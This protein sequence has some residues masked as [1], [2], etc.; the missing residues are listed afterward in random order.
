MYCKKCGATVPE[1]GSFCQKCG[2]AVD[3]STAE[4]PPPQAQPQPGPT[5]EATTTSGFAIAALV[6]GIAGFLIN[7]IA[8]LAV[9]FGA[10][11]MSQ[12][13]K[14][15]NLKGKGMAIA[16]LVMGIIVVFLWVIFFAWIGSF[17]WWI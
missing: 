14:N 8:V 7:F 4:S 2:A 1:G 3:Q 17:F 13:S 9:I 5:V 6:C 15:P 16:G 11:G 10:I 12:V